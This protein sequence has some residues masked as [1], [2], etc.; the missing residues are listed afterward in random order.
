MGKLDG[1]VVLV[2]GGGRGIGREIALAMARDGA[3][4]AVS[5]RTGAEL[6][7]VVTEAQSVGRR[8]LAVEAD[9]MVREQAQGAVAETLEC[10]KR[11][12]ILVNNVGGVLSG[13]GPQDQNP[14]TH[15]DDVFVDNLTLNL[16]T[17]YWTTR[18]ALPS[19]K[20]H[21]FGRVINIG[22]GYAKTSGGP[23]GYST[24]KHGV[25]GFT[26]AL[27]AQVAPFGITVNCL[28]PGW[29]N[30]R[31]IDIESVARRMGT[32]I[33]SAK[34]FLA[35]DNLLG[36]ILEPEELGPMAALLAAPESGGIT[37]QVISVDGGYRV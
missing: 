33:A 12:D 3:D 10:F 24:A 25:I 22:S 37:G 6:Q 18:A 15:D 21:G 13:K 9:A 29:T 32:D 30:T 1:L 23:L 31:L 7:E 11:L 16:V 28:C 17:H 20:E 2:T 14:F 8:A 5:S 4:I 36:R 19:M 34:A 26:R 27:A 35:R